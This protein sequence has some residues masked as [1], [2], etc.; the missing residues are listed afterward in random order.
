[1]KTCSG[2]S[3]TDNRDLVVAL[4]GGVGG[5]KLALGLSRVLPPGELMVVVNTGDDFDHLG[6]RVSPDIDTVLYTLSG[7]DNPTTGWGR[8]DET[9]NFMTALE[10]V[11]GATWFRLGDRDLAMHVE[12]TRRLTAG[13]T[14][15]EITTDFGRRLGV[16]TPIVP[17]SDDPVRTKVRSTG[18]WLDFQNYFV[19]HKCE[20]TVAELAFDGAASARPNPAFIAALANPRLRALVICPSNPFISIDPILAIPGVRAAIRQCAAPVVA[21]TPIIGGNSIKGPT[22]KMM[23]ELGLEVSPATVAQRYGDLLDG[24]V[25]DPADSG[26]VADIPVVTVLAPALMVTLKDREVLA[27]AVLAAADGLAARVQPRRAAAPR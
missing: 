10:A 20:P 25:L 18:G 6:L 14:L 3:M 21:V 8:R 13:E 22:A 23:R 12:R 4:S 9:W 1:M 19:E 26:I 16:A 24:Y 2:D 27:Q 15:S 17:M 5:A 7:L 11:G